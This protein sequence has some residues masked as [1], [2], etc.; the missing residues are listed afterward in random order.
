MTCVTFVR[1]VV[2]RPTNKLRIYIINNIYI[3]PH[4]MYF[5]AGNQLSWTSDCDLKRSVFVRLLRPLAEWLLMKSNHI[6]HAVIIKVN[7]E[8]SLIW[9]DSLSS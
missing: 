6:R 3:I 2:C 4:A 1:D 7:N 8:I 9:R 5:M